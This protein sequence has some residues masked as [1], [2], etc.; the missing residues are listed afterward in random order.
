MD[1]GL[2]AAIVGGIFAVVG[3]I[4][5]II[6]LFIWLRDWAASRVDKIA[7]VERYALGLI[8]DIRKENFRPTFVL[9]IGRSGAFLA[10]WLAGNLG[11]LP[12][13]VIDRVH[14]RKG[15][16]APEFNNMERKIQLL[17]DIYG[18]DAKVLVVEAADI[19]GRTFTKFREL[20]AS[21]TPNWDCKYC[22]IYT[23]AHLNS[24]IDFIA[25]RLKAVPKRLPWHR[26]PE[27]FQSHSVTDKK[28][29]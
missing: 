21:L 24:D 19:T 29:K 17:I 22:A 14:A 4:V 3:G 2:V 10:G 18:A 20:T 28:G 6:Q 27:Y 12:I 5:T 16:A 1:W 25:K 15:G 8:D 13:E 9:G 11:S 23:M 26:T 7:D